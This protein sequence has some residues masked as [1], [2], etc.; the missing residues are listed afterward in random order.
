MKHISTAGTLDS[1]IS[2]HQ[3]VFLIKNI[4]SENE[5]EEDKKSVASGNRKVSTDDE[6]HEEDLNSSVENLRSTIDRLTD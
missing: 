2:D 5:K 6:S 3:P 4:E 1:F